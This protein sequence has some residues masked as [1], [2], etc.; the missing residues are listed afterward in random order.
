[1]QR[2]SY[3]Y[4]RISSRKK[5]K[6]SLQCD[7]WQSCYFYNLIFLNMNNFFFIQHLYE[8]YNLYIKV[9]LTFTHS[10]NKIFKETKS[11]S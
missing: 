4:Q 1:M 7:V 2:A 3:R 8:G 9:T 11:I 5:K 6:S 10:S